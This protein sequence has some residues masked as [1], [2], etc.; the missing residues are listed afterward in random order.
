MLQWEKCVYCLA[1]SQHCMTPNTGRRTQRCDRCVRLKHGCS[2]RYC[3]GEAISLVKYCSFAVKLFRLSDRK[4]VCPICDNLDP[5]QNWGYDPNIRLPIE[6]SV[7][8]MDIATS[9]LCGCRSCF[10]LWQGLCQ[11]VEDVLVDSDIC[12]SLQKGLPLLLEYFNPGEKSLSSC[13]RAQV[14]EFY[15]ELHRPSI[16]SSIGAARSPIWSMPSASAIRLA[17][18]WLE[19]CMTN[20]SKC[21]SPRS[22][23]PNR[24]IHVG[25]DED[26]PHL[27]GSHQEYAHYIALSHCWGDYEAH[28]PLTTTTKT[29]KDR[30]RAIPLDSLPQTFKDAILVARWLGIEYLWIDSLCI[31]QDDANDWARESAQMHDIYARATLTINAHVSTHCDGG[32]FAPINRSRAKHTTLYPHSPSLSYPIH[33]HLTDIYE[34]N[35]G[36]RYHFS[37]R[38]SPL[39][40]RCWTLQEHILARRTLHFSNGEMIWECKTRCNCESQASETPFDERTTSISTP[41]RYYREWNE[42]LLSK[43]IPLVELYTKLNLTYERDRL[44]ALS[45]LAQ[46]MTENTAEHYVCGHWKQDLAASLLW[47]ADNSSGTALRPKRHKDYYVPTWSWA[48][49]SRGMIRWPR[50]LAPILDELKII[51]IQNTPAT[52]NPFGRSSFGYLKVA[53]LVKDIRVIRKEGDTIDIFRDDCRRPPSQYNLERFHPDTVDDNRLNTVD[54]IS[55]RASLDLWRPVVEIFPG[56]DLVILLVTDC[57]AIILKETTADSNRYQRVGIGVL[58]YIDWYGWKEWLAIFSKRTIYI[59]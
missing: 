19:D 59:V 45:G 23:L 49:L 3:A 57:Q 27:S 20:H 15:T 26:D 42:P 6:V 30:Q 58:R 17:K 55:I 24:I 56:D 44:H 11:L 34:D 2:R 13:G 41:A 46:Y 50:L 32:L 37:I 22:R 21:E 40:T 52:N 16:W 54:G 10:L 48:S 36:V 28:K 1:T 29:L 14:L 25:G 9:A 31:I 5:T 53:G 43:W 35:R 8:F 38:T 51:E 4:P 18:S 39:S 7:T 47:E 12:F 33:A